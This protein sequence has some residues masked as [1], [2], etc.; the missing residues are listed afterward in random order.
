MKEWKLY[1]ANLGAYVNGQLV[2]G[3]IDVLE[4][5]NDPEGLT[6]AIAKTTHG[7][8][9]SAIHDSEGGTLGMGENVDI[10]GI[11]ARAEAIEEHGFEVVEIAMDYVSGDLDFD[12]IN[13]AIENGYRGT[14]E[15]GADYAHDLFEE[16]GDIDKLP[17]ILRY[18]IDWEHVFRNMELR[19][20][21]VGYGK[22]I[23]WDP[24]C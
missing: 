8:E 10:S 23:I 22:S 11:L 6:A 5:C 13:T 9:E 2:G 18:C 19:E 7:A 14:H 24:N 17:E 12:V 15:C 16:T 4:F 3:W 20:H 21:A 1:F